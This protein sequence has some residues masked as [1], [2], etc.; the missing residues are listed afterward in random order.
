MDRGTVQSRGK[1]SV[2]RISGAYAF[3]NFRKTLI[4]RRKTRSRTTPLRRG[5]VMVN[6]HY[7]F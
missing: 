4:L 2:E 5:D 6:Y 1:L 3:C 7:L